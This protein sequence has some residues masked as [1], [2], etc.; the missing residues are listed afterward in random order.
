MSKLPIKVQVG[1]RDFWD[2]DDAPVQDSIKRLKELIGTE[3]VI[4]PEWQVLLTELDSFYPDKGTFVPRIASCVQAW[5]AALSELLDDAENEEWAEKILEQSSH[6]V[7]VYLEVTKGPKP[8]TSWSEDRKGFVIALP[9]AEMPSPM[10]S[11]SSFKGSLLNC[12]EESSK[13]AGAIGGKPS[14][15]PAVIDDWAD[16]AMDTKT[17]TA[18]VVETATPRAAPQLVHEFDVLPDC[19]TIPR[20]DD[21][22]LKPPYHMA[23]YERGSKSVEVYGSHS[24]SLQLLSDYLT[25]WCKIK[26]TDIRNPPV[27]DVQLHQ[28]PFGLGLVCDRLTLSIDDRNS[29]FTVT[30]MMVIPLIEGLLGYKSVYVDQSCWKFRRDIELR[31]KGF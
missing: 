12:F 10:E 25:K 20:P 6:R 18:A 16:V 5:C 4:Q 1:I 14:Q 7:M 28:A 3:I 17:G 19:S 30:T 15:R 23:V 21:L 9:K 13:P 22:L 26:H 8:I 31:K 2:R 27:V 29:M 24:P 11:I